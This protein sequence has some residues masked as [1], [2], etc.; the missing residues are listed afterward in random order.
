MASATFMT[1]IVSEVIFQI[2]KMQEIR[3]T[4]NGQN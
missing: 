1:W 3:I 2:E 4:P